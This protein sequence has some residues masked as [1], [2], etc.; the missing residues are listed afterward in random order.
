LYNY[1]LSGTLPDS[2]YYSN[3]NII[4]R[5]NLELLQKNESGCGFQ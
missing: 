3:V 2:C 1:L 5:S 4:F